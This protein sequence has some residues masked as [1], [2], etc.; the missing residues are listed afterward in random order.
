M[1]FQNTLTFD[2]TGYAG[3][4]NMV[5]EADLSVGDSISGY[6]IYAKNGATA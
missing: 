4:L 5:V 6:D 2:G 1:W 3:I